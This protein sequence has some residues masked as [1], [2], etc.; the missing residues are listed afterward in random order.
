MSNKVLIWDLPTRIFHW[1]LVIAFFVAYVSEEDLLTLH[2]WAGYSVAGLI[3]FRLLWGIIGN[4]YARFSNFLCNPGTAFR[5]LQDVMQLKAKRYLGHNPAGAWM[6]VML[7][8]GLSLAVFSGM[9][10]YAADQNAGPLVGVVGNQYE[11]LWEE[12]HE[13]FVNA[14][15]LLVVFHVLG[16]LLESYAHKENLAKSMVHGYKNTDNDE[17]DG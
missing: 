8:L 3:V 10:V 17:H 7:L 13:F 14:T 12:I 6:I 11:D 16:V 2:V 1:G 5:Y 15:L 4:R 9:A